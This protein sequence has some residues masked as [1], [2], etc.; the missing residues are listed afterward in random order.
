MVADGPCNSQENLSCKQSREV[1]NQIDWDCEVYRNYADSNLGCRERVSS[2]ISWAFEHVNEAIILEDDCLPDVSFFRYCENLLNYYRHDKRVMVISGN[3]FQ[4]GCWRGD[5]S[6]YFS[7]Y[8]HCWGWATWKRAWEKYD[9]SLSKWHKFKQTNLLSSLFSNHQ[10]VQYWT[11]IFDQ[12]KSQ[13]TPDTWDYCW[14]YS[15]WINSGLTILPNV[16]LVKN[17]GFGDLSTNTRDAQNPFADL[18]VKTITNEINHPSFVVR[19]QIAD[20]YT[21]EQMFKRNSFRHLLLK[22][23]ARLTRTVQRIV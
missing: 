7:Y 15:C 19:D 8:P 17:I 23:I 3:N 9:N 13:N 1:T 18:D 10:E 16:N 2:G 4:D 22:K 6:Y 5:G 20:S 14:A 11:S 21:F 12:I